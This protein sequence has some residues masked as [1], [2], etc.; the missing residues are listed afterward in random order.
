MDAVAQRARPAARHRGLAVVGE[1][2]PGAP[3]PHRLL[4]AGGVARGRPLQEGDPRGRHLA[5]AAHPGRGRRP[6]DAGE[7][8]DDDDDDD[9]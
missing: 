3:L 1:V 7:R 2:G 8:Y 4:H 6:G 5:P 9:W